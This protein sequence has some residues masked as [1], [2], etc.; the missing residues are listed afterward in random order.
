MGF[1][2]ADND[3]DHKKNKLVIVD[4]NLCPQDHVCPAV[5]ACPNGSLTQEGLAAPKV[6]GV[7]CIRCGKCVETCGTGA[8]LMDELIF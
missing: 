1:L 2:N 5:A 4:T 8:L 7:T 3:K 6:N